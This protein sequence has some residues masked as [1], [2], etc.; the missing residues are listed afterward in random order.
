[1]K[2]LS[3]FAYGAIV[4]G[5]LVVMLFDNHQF[6]QPNGAKGC[7][8][9]SQ[10]SYLTNHDMKMSCVKENGE[11]FVKFVTDD[12]QTIIGQ[13]NIVYQIGFDPQLEFQF[14]LVDPIDHAVLQ[15][16]NTC[17]PDDNQYVLISSPH[18]LRDL[19]TV[20]NVRVTCSDADLKYSIQSFV[21]I[22]PKSAVLDQ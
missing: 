5:F 19:S 1:M 14:D 17:Y 9:N 6:T 22:R 12:G 21:E 16:L 20:R 4:L 11:R 13:V 3:C 15:H 10:V 18:V 7:D 8:F 2:A